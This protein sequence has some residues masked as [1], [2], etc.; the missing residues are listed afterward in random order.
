MSPL[1]QVLTTVL[2]LFFL[3][4]L[5]RLVMDYVFMFARSYSPKGPMLV[6][7]EATWTVTDPPLKAIRRVI[8]PL[9]LGSVPLDLSFLVLLLAVQM[10]LSLASRL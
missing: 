1:G 3:L 4:L 5:L 7:C 10:L 6:V 2:W 8:P 9:R